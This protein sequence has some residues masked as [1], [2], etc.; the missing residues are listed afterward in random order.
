MKSRAITSKTF[1]RK[2]GFR[3][4]RVY[5]DGQDDGYGMCDFLIYNPAGE[6]VYNGCANYQDALTMVKG[7]EGYA[8]K[9]K[10]AK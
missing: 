8:I 7:Y 2:S 4:E 9:E 1:K 5:R 6:M 10:E 3:I